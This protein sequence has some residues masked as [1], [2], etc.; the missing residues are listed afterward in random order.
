MS[1]IHKK[2]TEVVF[3]GIDVIIARLGVLI[4][5]RRGNGSCFCSDAF[6]RFIVEWKINHITSSL[7]LPRE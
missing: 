6:R 1:E 3:R 2:T 5:I 4:T 7:Q